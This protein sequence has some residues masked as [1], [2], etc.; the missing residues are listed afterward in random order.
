MLTISLPG[1]MNY[2]NKLKA[3]IEAK[4][5]STSFKDCSDI[6]LTALPGRRAKVVSSITP[7]GKESSS[8]ESF[9]VELTPLDIDIN[10]GSVVSDVVVKRDGERKASLTSNV[11]TQIGQPEVLG[12]VRERTDNGSNTI[13]QWNSFP[14]YRETAIVLTA[15]PVKTADAIMLGS[16]IHTQTAQIANSLNLYTSLYVSITSKG[17]RDAGV[18]FFTPLISGTAARLKLEYDEL[19]TAALEKYLPDNSTFIG[20]EGGNRVVAGSNLGI[21]VYAGFEATLMEDVNFFSKWYLASWGFNPTNRSLLPQYTMGLRLER[22]KGLGV[23]LSLSEDFESNT[24][25]GKA[26]MTFRF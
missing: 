11:R 5:S 15:T 12:I 1:G 13:G 22:E 7:I 20:L 17:N 21:R 9:E 6:W 4:V 23:Q 26:A 3:E 8:A 18:E 14:K 10:T 19:V 2:N 16:G 25:E 24:I